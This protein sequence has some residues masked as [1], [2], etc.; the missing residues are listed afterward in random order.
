V[1]LLRQCLATR[2]PA[3]RGTNDE[4]TEIKSGRVTLRCSP[5]A[6]ARY[7]YICPSIDREEAL[8]DAATES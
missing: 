6:S 4:V 3:F 8:L 1:P 2:D 5:K 7:V